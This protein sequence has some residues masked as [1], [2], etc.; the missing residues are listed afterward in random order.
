M[1][2]RSIRHK[3][4]KVDER[5][6]NS[7]REKE[8]GCRDTEMGVF[9]DLIKGMSA[10]LRVVVSLFLLSVVPDDD[11]GVGFRPDRALLVG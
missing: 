1:F 6:S 9:T 11:I 7:P 4:S 3:C 2:M 8:K 5:N 10:C